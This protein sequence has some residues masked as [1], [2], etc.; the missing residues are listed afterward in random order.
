MSEQT[1]S[2]AAILVRLNEREQ[3]ITAQAACVREQIEQL[4]GH[5]GELGRQL[6]NVQITRKTL[7]ELP[8]PQVPGAPV[9]TQDP[10]EHPAWWGGV[11]NEG[12]REPFRDC[13]SVRMRRW[14]Q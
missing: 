8:E 10:P 5:L 13:A 9:L 11:T 6:E 12:R 14:A 2:L 1:H 7:A 3:Q 4:T